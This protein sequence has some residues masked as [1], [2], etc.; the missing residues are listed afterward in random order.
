MRREEI[1]QSRY[2]LRLA[3]KSSVAEDK[4]CTVIFIIIREC[5]FHELSGLFTH[6][7]NVIHFN[8]SLT[9]TGTG[10]LR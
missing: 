7:D 10:K 1:I 6:R 8:I 9:D 5:F 3:S 2:E 4:G